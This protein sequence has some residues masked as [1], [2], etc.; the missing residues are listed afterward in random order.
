VKEEVSS[1]KEKHD[2]MIVLRLDADTFLVE[3]RTGKAGL[4]QKEG[5]WGCIVERKKEGLRGLI[6]DPR[7]ERGVKNGR[8]LEDLSG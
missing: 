6:M 3:G 4:V 5:L 2:R 8:S 1:R 7:G